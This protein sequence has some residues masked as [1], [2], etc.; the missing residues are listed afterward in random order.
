M[1]WKGVW[2][3]SAWNVTNLQ[4]ILSTGET[5]TFE[6]LSWQYFLLG[7]YYLIQNSQTV[8]KECG[9]QKGYGEKNVKSKV[10]AK[11]WL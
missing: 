11:K 2:I 10:A 5:S 7:I 3:C 1:F 6:S 9:L 8:K 4:L